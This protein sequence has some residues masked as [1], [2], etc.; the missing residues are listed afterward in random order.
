MI[1]SF[2]ARSVCVDAKH[3]AFTFVNPLHLW[4]V[5]PTWADSPHCGSIHKPFPGDAGPR[6]LKRPELSFCR[7]I[8]RYCIY[9]K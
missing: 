1:L 7:Q 2:V 9:N 3:G 5:S 8:H 4:V 6:L